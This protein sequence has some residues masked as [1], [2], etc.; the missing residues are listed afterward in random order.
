MVETVGYRNPVRLH[1]VKELERAAKKEDARIWSAVAGAL[2]KSRK[3]R[4]EVNVYRLNKNTSD[5][6]VV[7]VPGS[8][9][10][11]GKLTHKVVVAAF[12][13][14]EGARN[15]ILSAGGK[16]LSIPELIKENSKG[17]GVR[18]IS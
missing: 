3:N 15:E 17:S 9:V 4:P 8:V 13:F 5:G 10:G 6:D 1:L 2:S 18:I 7:V 11:S 14:T 12:K 16:V